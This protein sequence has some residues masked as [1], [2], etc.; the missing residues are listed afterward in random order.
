MEKYV[1]LRNDLTE[2][3]TISNIQNM[4]AKILEVK[5]DICLFLSK[6]IDGLSEQ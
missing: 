3:Q 4:E 5:K 2:F 1:Q 6:R